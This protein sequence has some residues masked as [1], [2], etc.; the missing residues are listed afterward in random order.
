M[1]FNDI[2]ENNIFELANQQIKETEFDNG[3][4]LLCTVDDTCKLFNESFDVQDISMSQK[5]GKT[6]FIV[7]GRSSKAKHAAGRMKVSKLIPNNK[8]LNTSDHNNM[9]SFYV[10][11][12]KLG[13]V[14]HEYDNNINFSDFKFS[15]IE[16]DSYDEICRRNWNLIML[17]RSGNI[18][19]Y[20]LENNFIEDEY[21]RRAGVY[22]ERYKDG[23]IKYID[24]VKNIHGATIR[25]EYIN[26]IYGNI[27]SEKI[28]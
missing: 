13:T 24:T 27:I 22:F 1:I 2:P 15:K 9:V 26:D 6:R 7:I 16:L 10:T 21:R 17:T 14:A 11:N 8:G 3:F 19:E 23:R 4:I 20:V 25:K 28:I 18:D 12:E 5:K